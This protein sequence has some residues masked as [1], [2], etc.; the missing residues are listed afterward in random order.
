MVLTRTLGAFLVAAM[1]WAEAGHA[2]TITVAS[3]N[4]SNLVNFGSASGNLSAV[5]SGGWSANKQ[6][7]W[8][9]GGSL[10]GSTVSTIQVF[11]PSTG[12]ATSIIDSSGAGN[13]LSG[14]GSFAFASDGTLWV[15]SADNG[16]LLRYDAAGQNRT[17][18]SAAWEGKR[19]LL[20]GPDG[21]LYGA[22]ASSIAKFNPATNNSFTII[23][24]AGAGNPLN[25]VGAMA[26]GPD[27][28]LW[29]TSANNGNLV[30]YSTATSNNVVSVAET[31]WVAKQQL[32]WDEDGYLYATGGSNI[33]K[34]DRTSRNSFTLIDDN[35]GPISG[36]AAFAY[37]PEPSGAVWVVVGCCTLLRRGTRRIPQSGR[38]RGSST[39]AAF[40]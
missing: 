11:N 37:V 35:S 32:G 7:A 17:V 21:C 33:L 8:G 10:Y 16:N 2:G 27:G 3:L 4:N 30:R 31:N 12:N 13:P 28:Y 20:W 26:F 9:P 22:G 29:V 38:R 25:G 14:V 24:S 23:D 39:V 5:L 36:V 34:Y 19:N 40:R 1:F 18:L 15:A 6:I